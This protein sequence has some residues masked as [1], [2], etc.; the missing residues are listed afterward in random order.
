MSERLIDPWLARAQP[1]T[2]AVPPACHGVW[3]RTLL[4]TPDVRD[5][6]TFVRWMQLGRWHADLRI[7][8]AALTNRQAL[9]LSQCLPAQRALLATQQGFSGVTQVT[10][11]AASDVCTWHRLVDYEAPRAT[12]DTGLL[13][14]ETSERMVETGVYGV[15]REVWQRLPQSATGLL[16]L[17]EPARG[18][19]LTSARLFMAGPYLM[20]VRPSLQVG[21]EFEISFGVVAAGRW[22]IQQSTLPEL[23]GQNLAFSMRLVGPTQAQLQGDV[24]TGAWDILERDA[25]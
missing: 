16:A 23:E 20:R 13:V 12:P 24:G 3:V 2:P 4:E 18:D 25:G 6:T 17:A 11:G 7:P 21:P 9:P 10:P 22:Q 1:D 19:G 15:Y 5:D 8:L 14:F